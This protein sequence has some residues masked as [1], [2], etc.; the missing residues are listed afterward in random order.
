MEV[1]E[2]VGVGAF[3]SIA[4]SFLSRCSAYPVR[5]NRRAQCAGLATTTQATHKCMIICIFHGALKDNG[6]PTAGA[7][8]SGK[9]AIAQPDETDVVKS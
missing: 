9:G 7:K 8:P 2:Q 6:S 3:L 4:I 5:A 1:Q